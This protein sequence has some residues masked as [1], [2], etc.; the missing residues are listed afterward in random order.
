L[1]R[2]V[3]KH[4]FNFIID[5]VAGGEAVYE[6]AVE[7]HLQVADDQDMNKH[8]VTSRSAGPAG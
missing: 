1:A 5:L 4:G 2:A 3:V 8:L 6:F 7:L